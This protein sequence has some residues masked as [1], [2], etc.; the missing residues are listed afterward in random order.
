MIVDF[1]FSVRGVTS[2]SLDPHKYGFAL[3][4]SSVL[5]YA[6]PAL[7]Q[8]QYFCYPEWTGGLYT[9]PTIAGSRSG[10][11]IA[12]C[13]ASMV[14]LGY[15]GYSDRVTEIVAVTRKIAAG[16]SKISG[17]KLLGPND[18]IIVCFTAS[19]PEVNI[20][21]VSD[22]LAGKGWGLN[23]LQGPACVHLC[24]THAHINVVDTFLAD[25]NEAV[26]FV[27][28]HP[29]LSKHGSAAVYGMTSSIPSGPV[30]DILKIY[31]DVVLDL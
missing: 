1:D 26:E 24:V 4:G 22:H 14:S 2:M 21:S 18:T 27:L 19:C 17:L 3:K 5:L 7:R 9:T 6:D 28:K 30:K 12:S 25:V 8:A 16:I 31:N 11:L 23:T 13:W 20:Y 15:Q 29:E 10:G